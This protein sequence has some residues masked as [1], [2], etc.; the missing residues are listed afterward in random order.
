MEKILSTIKNV[1]DN[2]ELSREFLKRAKRVKEKANSELVFAREQLI[3][4][5]S[6]QIAENAYQ[7]SVSQTLQEAPEILKGE[8]ET[9]VLRNDEYAYMPLLM[10]LLDVANNNEL[11]EILAYGGGWAMTIVVKLLMDEVAGDI[12]DYA[13]A[14]KAAR[15]EM[16]VGK[17]DAIKA[18]KIWKDKIYPTRGRAG[19]YGHTISTRLSYLSS[20]APY[21]SLLNNGNKSA[22]MASDRG[23]IA[24]PN[25]GGTHFVQHAEEKIQKIF[26]K[27][28][29][30]YKEQNKSDIQLLKIQIDSVVKLL[31]DLDLTIDEIALRLDNAKA[32]ARKLGKTMDQ[33]DRSKLLDVVERV[34]SGELLTGRVNIGK[35][36]SRVRISVSRIARL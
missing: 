19:P 25:R 1:T 8:I 33:I 34:S 12:Q 35:R 15:E 5:K 36:G 29:L 4:L 11:Y 32:I 21:W 13:E 27:F 10:P 30:E 18:S 28:F 24:Y 20:Q 14:V 7:I 23:G 16:N 3:N 6:P 9:A 31:V 17:T 2:A 26:R 22:S